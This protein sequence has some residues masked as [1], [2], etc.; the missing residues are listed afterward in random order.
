MRFS[1]KK[2]SH[3]LEGQLSATLMIGL[4]DYAIK[5]HRAGRCITQD[6]V[7]NAIMEAMGWM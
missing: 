2:V 3:T 6:Q 7:K 5:E 4:V 1:E